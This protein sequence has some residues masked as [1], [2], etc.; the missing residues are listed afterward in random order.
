MGSLYFF[1]S[2]LGGFGQDFFFNCGGDGV[3]VFF[4]VVSGD[5]GVLFFL[6]FFING[7]FL[8]FRIV[9]FVII[10]GKFIN[11]SLAFFDTLGSDSHKVKSD[12]L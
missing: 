5:F 9:T 6:K 4:D 1:E 11:G 12:V 3:V 10:T 7:V 2:F 8:L